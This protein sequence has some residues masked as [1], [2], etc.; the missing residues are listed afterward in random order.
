VSREKRVLIGLVLLGVAV[1]VAYVLST[2]HLALGGDQIEYDRE[3]RFILQGHWF[4]TTAPYGIA[5][6]GMWKAPG[7]PVWLAGWYEL[8]GVHVNAVRLVQVLIFGPVNIVLAWVLAR[9]LFG[10]AP[11]L[12]TAGILAVYPLAFQFEGLLF[13]EGLGAALTLLVLITVLERE[14]T[15]GRAALA[16][17]LLA[18]CVLVR[19][20]SIALAAPIAV[21]WIVAAR[22]RRGLAMGLVSALVLVVVVAPW[23]ARNQRVSGAFIPL[24]MQD[25]ASYG[26]FND[27]A[28]HDKSA[29]WAWRAVTRRDRDLFDPRH[30][31]SDAKLRRELQTRSRD[32]IKAHPT[33]VVKAFFWNGLSRLWD[34]R[35]PSEALA[36][37]KPQG[38]SRPWTIAGLAMYYV[39]APFALGGLW[40]NRRRL[41]LV[42]PVLALVLAASIVQTSDAVTR[43]RAPLEPLIVVLAAPALLYVVGLV[44]RAQSSSVEVP[45]G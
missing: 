29:P 5:H 15:L 24:S 19:P 23:T 39:L 10:V 1:R 20:S 16:G 37:V 43:Y 18:G 21:A 30:P 45:A 3:A 38:R 33:A 6:A 13:S 44:R 4:W 42:L 22:F 14:P 40:L 26:T 8:L 9:R 35:R 17:L 2:R 34:V 12:L 32:Y 28:A 11:A 7:Y 36:E 27:D 25:A 31:L 41:G